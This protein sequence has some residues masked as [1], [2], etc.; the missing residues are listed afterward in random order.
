MSELAIDRPAARRAGPFDRKVMLLLVAAGAVAF[1][2]ALLLAAYAPDLQS[3]RNGGSHALSKG[4]T[5]FSGL[6]R[7][8]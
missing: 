6:V 1:I 8:A 5:G 7:L 2:A 4:A 3:G